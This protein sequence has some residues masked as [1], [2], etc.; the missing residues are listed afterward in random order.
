MPP[1]GELLVFSEHAE[2]G[3][4]SPVV[5]RQTCQESEV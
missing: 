5:Q 4:Q 1:Q 2:E 3:S